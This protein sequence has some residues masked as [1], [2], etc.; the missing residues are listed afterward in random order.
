LEEHGRGDGVDPDSTR[1]SSRAEPSGPSL[2]TGPSAAVS[3]DR[4]R[5]QTAPAAGF[6]RRQP[7]IV[8]HDRNIEL[9]FER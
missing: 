2:S 4:I 6:D 3:S 9:R 5:R 1:P 8:Q 7:L